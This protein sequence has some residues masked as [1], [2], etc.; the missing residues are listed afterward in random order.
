MAKTSATEFVFKNPSGIFQCA[1]AVPN[2]ALLI[3]R[4]AAAIKVLV[5][6]CKLIS[7]PDFEFTCLLDSISFRRRIGAI[8]IGFSAGFEPLYIHKIA[9]ADTLS[10]KQAL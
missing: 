8:L 3:A 2:I 5:I 4:V 6:R 1:M 7:I 10:L 9:E